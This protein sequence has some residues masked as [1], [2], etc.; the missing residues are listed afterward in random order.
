MSAATCAILSIGDMGLGIAKLLM[1]NNY[2]VI[3]SIAGRSQ[4]TLDRAKS[5]SINVVSS[6]EELV[7]E[8]D[9]ILSIVP[10]RDAVSTAERIV[11]ASARPAFL[12]RKIPLYFIDLNAISPKTARQIDGLFESKEAHVRFTDGG[13]IGGPPRFKGGGPPTSDMVSWVRPSIPVS[14]PYPL[15]EAEM[16]GA[17]LAKVLNIQHVAGEIGPASGLKMTFAS[18]TKGLTAL[19][20]QSFTTA[21]RLGVL[22]ELQE[23]LEQYSPKTLALAQKG[24]TGMP[25]KAYRWVGEMTEIGDTFTEDGGFTGDEDIFSAVSK[26]YE[27]VADGTELGSERTGQKVE[28]RTAA[29]VA[30]L[31]SKGIDMRKAKLD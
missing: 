26:T 21:H 22:P 16:S 7:D 13:I 29:E 11:K 8:A 2:R 6:D 25:H 9:Y 20:I 31:I 5:A 30:A 18:L 19:T 27:L 10:P 17:K 4:G 12:A 15:S 24:I 28:G 3:T 14:G 23:H 1:A